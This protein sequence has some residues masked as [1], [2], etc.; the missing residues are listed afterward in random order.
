MRQDNG[1]NEWY[2]LWVSRGYGKSSAVPQQHHTDSSGS[3]KLVFGQRRRRSLGTEGRIAFEN[4]AK[5][6]LRYR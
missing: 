5:G 6:T 2:D 3:A 1:Q 4:L